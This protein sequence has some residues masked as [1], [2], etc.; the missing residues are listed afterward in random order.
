M[1]SSLLFPYLLSVVCGFWLVCSLYAFNVPLLPMS[2][3]CACLMHNC[4][5]NRS[6]QRAF[7]LYLLNTKESITWQG[8]YGEHITEI[9]NRVLQ[10]I[11]LCAPANPY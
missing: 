1:N 7:A 3:P 9:F 8:S 5:S 10:G 4:K 2:Y 11:E 6:Q